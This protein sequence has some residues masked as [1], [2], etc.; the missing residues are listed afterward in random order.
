MVFP[1]PSEQ[2]CR[3]S[4]KDYCGP[5]SGLQ[6][7]SINTVVKEHE[8]DKGDILQIPALSDFLKSPRRD[9]M[10]YIWS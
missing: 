9:Y 6:S 4:M 8:I 2:N 7:L 3:E 10:A 5:K 1:F